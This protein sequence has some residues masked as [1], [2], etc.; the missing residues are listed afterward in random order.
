[1][2]SHVILNTPRLHSYGAD[3]SLMVRVPN[4][5]N[6]WPWWFS[7]NWRGCGSRG[8]RLRNIINLR[9]RPA[10]VCTCLPFSSC[11]LRY[12]LLGVA[13]GRSH[14]FLLFT[15]LARDFPGRDAARRFLPPPLIIRF[16]ITLAH[17][18]STSTPRPPTPN[19]HTPVSRRSQYSTSPETL[20]QCPQS[21]PFD[22]HMLPWLNPC[23]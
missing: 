4:P 13:V 17:C 12:L 14:T 21:T 2:R 22:I 3:S 6:I 18:S 5:R 11:A 15:M 1:M 23:Q 19:K 16:S 9:R 8:L 7:I 10:F 20:K